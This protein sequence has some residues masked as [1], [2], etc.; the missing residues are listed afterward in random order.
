[1]KRRDGGS[2]ARALFLAPEAPY[3]LHGGGAIRSASLLEYLATRYEVDVIVFREPGASDPC[4]AFPDR[5]TRSVHVI[6][7][8]FHRKDV[9]SRSLRAAARMARGIPPLNDRFGGFAAHV[10]AL[11][12]NRRYDIGVIEHFWCAPYWRQLAPACG[13]LVLNLHNIESVLH[14]RCARGEPPHIRSAHRM[15]HAA[16]RKMEREWLPRFDLLLAASDCDAALVR[17]I[18]PE[19][20]VIV[21]PNA[22]PDGPSPQSP[23][24]D[25]VA[26]SGN[27]AYH[28]NVSAVRFFAAEIWPLLRER[29]PGLL[30]RLIGRNPEAV[31]KHTRA[32]TRIQTTGPVPDAVRELASAKV[33]VAPL[34]AGSGTRLKI[35]EAWAAGRAVVATAIG[36]EGLPARHGENLLLADDP[37]DFAGA[38]SSLLESS[39]LR[40]RLGRAGR[41]LF[42]REF[43][44]R[45]AWLR[46]DL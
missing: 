6:D 12:R 46:L 2:P 31:W 45:S 22:L 36:A 41:V 9:F 18:A 37:R 39:E 21:Y 16:A 25:V 8:P 38:V 42:E 26:F 28:P 4:S 44:W 10:A 30:W 11:V 27:L 23:E 34:L 33:V 5:I 14:E 20:K 43:T 3:P 40:E 13:M 19:S 32:D 29:W 24:E 35:L 15:F 7:L 1:M 17:D